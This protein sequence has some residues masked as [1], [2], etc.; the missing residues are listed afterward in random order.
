MTSR[1]ELSVCV[2]CASQVEAIKE[3]LGGLIPL[4]RCRVIKVTTE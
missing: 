4:S 1:Q 3:K 2:L